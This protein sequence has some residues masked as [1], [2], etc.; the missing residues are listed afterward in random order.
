MAAPL[1]ELE[2]MCEASLLA[3]LVVPVVAH[4]SRAGLTASVT[5]SA[6]ALRAPVAAA[7]SS[8]NGEGAGRSIEGVA[9]PTSVLG[10]LGNSMRLDDLRI[11]IRIHVCIRECTYAYTHIW[12]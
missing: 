2:V 10:S 9:L 12:P 8:T 7:T 3:V 4:A 1:Q 5:A 6:S 11:C